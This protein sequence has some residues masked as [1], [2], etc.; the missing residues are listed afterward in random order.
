M[1][2]IRDCLFSQIKEVVIFVRYVCPQR[3]NAT[4][5]KPKQNRQGPRS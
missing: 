2:H 1:I 5:L 3:M 4:I